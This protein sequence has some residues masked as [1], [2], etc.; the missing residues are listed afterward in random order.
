MALTQTYTAKL[1]GSRVV[2]HY[3]DVCVHIRVDKQHLQTTDVKK[4]RAPF[5]MSP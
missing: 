2:F 3:V 4:E 5:D 1:V